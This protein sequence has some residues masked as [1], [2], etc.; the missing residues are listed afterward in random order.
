M[1]TGQK[2]RWLGEEEK[3]Q[4][5]HKR[6]QEDPQTRMREDPMPV[7]IYRR[8]HG[9]RVRGLLPTAGSWAGLGILAWLPCRPPSQS[10]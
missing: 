4:R 5:R 8:G 9:K 6:G 2:L 1:R 10:I 3:D 7:A